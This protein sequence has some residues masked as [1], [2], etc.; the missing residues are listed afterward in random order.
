MLEFFR[1][2]KSPPEAVPS[3]PRAL[4]PTTRMLVLR[5]SQVIVA[6]AA[7][8]AIATLVFLLGYAAGAPGGGDAPAAIGPDVWVIRAIAYDG[9]EGGLGLA[10]SVKRQLEG[11]DLGREVALVPVPSEKRTVVAVGSWLGDPQGRAEARALRDRLRGIRDE[12]TREAPFAGAE[13]WRME[14]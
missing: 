14:R 12:R 9:D 10:R 7:S 1:R 3:E 6:G 2:A 5:R 11:M 4:E 8:I 13:F